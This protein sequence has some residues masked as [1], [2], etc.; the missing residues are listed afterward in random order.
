[1]RRGFTSRAEPLP[2]LDEFCLNLAKSIVGDPEG[3]KVASV[4]GSHLSVIELDAPPEEIGRVVGR[5]GRT[6]AAIR[7]LAEA[8]AMRLNRRVMVD[9]QAAGGSGGGRRP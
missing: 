6:I 8:L 4:E 5:D 2:E 9:V 3:L 7:T 1:M